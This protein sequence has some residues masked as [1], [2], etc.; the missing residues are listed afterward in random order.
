MTDQARR[1]GSDPL[2]LQCLLR[3]LASLPLAF[4][5]DKKLHA[6]LLQGDG[7]PDVLSV[8]DDRTRDAYYLTFS[9]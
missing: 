2:L 5:A 8:G 3:D 1:D 9:N 6:Q 4:F 7:D